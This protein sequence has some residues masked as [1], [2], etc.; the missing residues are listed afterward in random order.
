VGAAVLRKF[1]E[2]AMVFSLSDG[3]WQTPTATELGRW[4][5]KKD[6]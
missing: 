3:F 6:Q 1:S 4:G 5:Y 2:F